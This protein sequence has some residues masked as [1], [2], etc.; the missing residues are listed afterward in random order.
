MHDLPDKWV[1]HFDYL[2]EDERWESRFVQYRGRVY[3]VFDTTSVPRGSAL[4]G[5]DS[6][7]SDSYFSGVVFRL[8]D[9]STV[10]CGTYYS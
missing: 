9:D 5:W 2:S 6:Y 4:S 10:V 8:V 1:E 7:H 3:D